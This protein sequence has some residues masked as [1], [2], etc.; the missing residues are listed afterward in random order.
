MYIESEINTTTLNIPS[1]NVTFI[2]VMPHGIFCN[3][4]YLK[5]VL[6]NHNKIFE[7]ITEITLGRT[8]N[9]C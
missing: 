3:N 1:F 8:V 6:P 4:Q 9:E 7:E 2:V 5:S